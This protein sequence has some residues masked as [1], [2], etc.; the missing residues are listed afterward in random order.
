MPNTTVSKV[1]ITKDN[2]TVLVENIRE[3]LR[4]INKGYLAIAPDVQKLYDVLAKIIGDSEG[5]NI[6]FTVR[7][8]DDCEKE[9]NI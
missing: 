7:R 1:T 2:A 6:K 9:D 5:V 8:R 3:G 4:T